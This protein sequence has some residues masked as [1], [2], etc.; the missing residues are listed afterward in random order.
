MEYVSLLR[1]D[2]E[3][4]RNSLILPMPDL[5]SIL[6]SNID[7]KLTSYVAGVCDSKTI[8][9]WIEGEPVPRDA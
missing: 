1:P 4:Q 3:A 8:E 5:L 7:K 6:T 2:L 9:S